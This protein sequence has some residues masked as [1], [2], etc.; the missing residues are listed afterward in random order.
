MTDNAKER[1]A[2]KLG[3][4]KDAL[5]LV[6]NLTALGVQIRTS[7]LLVNQPAIKTAYFQAINKD[8]PTDPGVK[9]ILK[10]LVR[11]M[12]QSYESEELYTVNVND[13]ALVDAIKRGV[14]KEHDV[15][16]M[17]PE[18]AR[19]I[20]SS[21]K[22]FINAHDLKETTGNMQAL[23]TLSNGFGRDTESID[24]RNESINEL[25]MELNDKEFAKTS[26]PVDSRPIFNEEYG[27]KTYQAR[28]YT[29]YLSLIH[30]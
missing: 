26:I 22:Q 15:L 12:E 21:M 27:A 2:A 29:I 19:F 14:G 18:D 23:V 16:E 7:V 3:L 30:I 28:Y 4:N 25:G 9:T 5:A 6:T 10:K 20:Y 11:A 17:A 24:A 13:A 1:L 8:Q